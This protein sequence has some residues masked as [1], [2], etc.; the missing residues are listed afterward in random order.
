MH[1]KKKKFEF[2]EWLNSFGDLKVENKRTCKVILSLKNARVPLITIYQLP[3]PA[4][5]PLE[6]C[7]PSSHFPAGAFFRVCARV[8][9]RVRARAHVRAW[10]GWPHPLGP[11]LISL[12]YPQS[13]V[14]GDS[15]TPLF[16]AQRAAVYCC[17]FFTA[18]PPLLWFV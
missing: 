8:R 2:W 16:P 17:R 15:R 9:A 12:S 18:R 13:W 11:T 1:R 14:G 7:H 5:F 4:S 3:V 6:N 10:P